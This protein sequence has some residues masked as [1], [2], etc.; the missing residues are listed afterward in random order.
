[1]CFFTASIA[2]AVV[3]WLYEDIRIPILNGQISL[4]DDRI[5]SLE[6]HGSQ[7]G[8]ASISS[9]VKEAASNIKRIAK[10]LLLTKAISGMNKLLIH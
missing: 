2:T 8:A 7:L 1:V 6:D 4:R 10:I 5:K 3:I 9:P